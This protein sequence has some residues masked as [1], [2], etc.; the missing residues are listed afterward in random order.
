[1]A[2]AEG[3]AVVIARGDVVTLTV[4]DRTV[5]AKVVLASPNG[6]SLILAF[7]A[8]LDGHVGMMPVFQDDDGIY[9]ALISGTEVTIAEKPK[10]VN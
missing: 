2:D 8:M 9:R 1:V 6:R 3:K 7:E 4:E 5:D 10:W